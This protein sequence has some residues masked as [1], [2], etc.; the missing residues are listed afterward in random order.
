MGLILG[1][2]GCGEMY[3]DNGEDGGGNVAAMGDLND[4]MV[5]IALSTQ[6]T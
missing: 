1:V 2:Q 4:S 3:S 5:T 6:S